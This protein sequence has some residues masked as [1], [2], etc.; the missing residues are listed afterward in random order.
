M[1]GSVRRRYAVRTLLMNTALLPELERI[2]PVD[3]ILTQAEDLLAYSYD[4]TPMMQQKPEA[5]VFATTP[6]EVAAV[7]RF[8]NEKGT[9][10]VTRGSGTGLS[11]GSVPVAGAL[12]LCLARM[13]R[14][15]EFDTANLTMLVE[16]GVINADI[17]A[18]AES[19]GLF[20]PPDPGSM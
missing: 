4:G 1:A 20:Y 2:I 7:L 5:V 18:R 12:V 14:I 17:Q 13:N 8:A 6:E 16:P 15:L 3:R 19:E 9:P 11:A 10:V